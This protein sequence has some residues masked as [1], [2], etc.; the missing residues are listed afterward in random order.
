M[1]NWLFERDFMP[2]GHCWLWRPDILWTHVV[3][4]GV[5]ALAY[6][7]IPVTLLYFARQ[8]KDLPFRWVFAFFAAFIV[9]CGTTHI[10][11]I[12]TI[13]TPVYPMEGVIK[14]LTALVSIVTA[15]ALVPLVPEALRLRSPRELEDINQKLQAEITTRREV[16][17]KL[18]LTVEN[19]YRSN[20]E[21]E[22]F[23]NVASHDLQSP[24]RGII[25]FTQ[26]LRRECQNKVSK[27]ADEF[28]ES[29]ERSGKHM[30][31]LINDLLQLSRVDVTSAPP[32]KVNMGAAVE[33]AR[34][35]L[36]ANL[37]TKGTLLHVGEMPDV[38]GDQAQLSQLFQNLIENA[39]KFQKPG[40]KPDIRVSAAR[41]GD[42]WHLVV[43]DNGIGIPPGQLENI[44]I[45]FR[46]LHGSDE[47]PG[48]GIGLSLCKKIVERHGGR[49]WAESTPGKGSRFHFTLRATDAQ[50][51]MKAW[52]RSASFVLQGA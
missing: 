46:R 44:F 11:N 27:E 17:H 25:S 41:E 42:E 14:G 2:H 8:R 3:S 1:F 51:P 39:A 45:I 21:L 13:W 12:W 47:F 50:L 33:Q 52:T 5:I 43:E 18:E 37:K 48:T 49:I 30:N 24:L 15:S 4:D 38:M 9:L 22:Q 28:F 19:L 26:L 32:A 35:Q 10:F 34:V 6:F 7:S 31:A 20:Q 23:A 16:E 40:V 29:I 36:G